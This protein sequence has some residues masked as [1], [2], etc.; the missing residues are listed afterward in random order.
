MR[1]NPP[2]FNYLLISSFPA[3]LRRTLNRHP[4]AQ[5]TKIRPHREARDPE[6]EAV[7]E[8]YGISEGILSEIF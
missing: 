8:I 5:F 4:S 1:A 2:A 7:V 6:M 3:L